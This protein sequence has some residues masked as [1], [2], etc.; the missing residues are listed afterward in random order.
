MYFITLLISLIKLRPALGPRLFLSVCWSISSDC[1][2]KWKLQLN[3][4][5]SHISNLM[6][7][8]FALSGTLIYFRLCNMHFLIKSINFAAKVQNFN[9]MDRHTAGTSHITAL[10]FSSLCK[11]LRTQYFGPFNQYR[12]AIPNTVSLTPIKEEELILNT[13]VH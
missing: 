12:V 1:T 5:A 10:I 13:F 11:I 2:V 4:P 6:R 7:C 8:V 3:Y 9:Y